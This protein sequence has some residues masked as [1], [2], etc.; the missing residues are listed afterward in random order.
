MD[1]FVAKLLAMT[2]ET[3]SIVSSDRPQPTMRNKRYLSLPISLGFSDA[4]VWHT[5]RSLGVS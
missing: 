5:L 2:A 4:L 3:H 1:R